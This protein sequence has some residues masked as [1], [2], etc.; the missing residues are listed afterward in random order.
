MVRIILSKPGMCKGEH[1]LL[2]SDVHWICLCAYVHQ[3]NLCEIPVGLTME[4]PNEARVI[5]EKLNN[6]II[7]QVMWI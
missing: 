1:I 4:G 7:G 5:P 3:H 6:M 2:V